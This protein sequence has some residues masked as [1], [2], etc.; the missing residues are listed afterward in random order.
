MD[1]SPFFCANLGRLDPETHERFECWAKSQQKKHLLTK[2][3]NDFLLFGEREDKQRKSH[4]VALRTTLSNWDVKL[5]LPPDFLKLVSKEE[6]EAAG[7]QTTGAILT[8]G[9][10]SPQT[11]DVSPTTCPA[12]TLLRLSPGFDE[13]SGAM[14]AAIQAH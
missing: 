2:A 1:T 4:M 13:R 14:L 10:P 7:Q 9:A 8:P 12:Q 11:C 6:F 3:G 5:Q